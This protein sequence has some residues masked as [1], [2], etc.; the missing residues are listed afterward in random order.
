[1]IKENPLSTEA[2]NRSTAVYRALVPQ[3]L[4]CR[5]DHLE[6][7]LI[8]TL[9]VLQQVD[10]RPSSVDARLYARPTPLIVMTIATGD[11]VELEYTGSRDDGTV[12]D[13]SRESVA[14]ET[15]LA[16][17]QPTR[18]YT[19]LTVEIGAGRIIEGLEDALVGLKEGAST[20][21]AIPPEKAYG[22]WSEDQVREYDVD[23]LSQTLD[24]QTPEKGV[25]IETKDGTQGEI[26]QVDDGVARI[27]FNS[28]LAGETLEFDIEVLR[29]N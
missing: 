21:V 5:A 16:T 10:S 23:E 4:L 15:G 2:T 6:S 9:N 3:D 26:V 20:T 24:G 1:M 14:Y 27:D 17:S 22:E 11:T 12:F 25:Y 29:V 28:P 8:D 19:P 18:E 13:T 7:G